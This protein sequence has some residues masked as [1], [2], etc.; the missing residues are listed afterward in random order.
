MRRAIVDC[1]AQLPEGTVIGEDLDA[2]RAHETAARA[3]GHATLF[4]SAEKPDGIQ[5]LSPGLLSLHRKLKRALDPHG[6]FGPGRLHTE[7]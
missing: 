3:G 5:R 6:I 7:F 1:G 2:D 4:R